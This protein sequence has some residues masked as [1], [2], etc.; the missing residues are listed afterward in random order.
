MQRTR[1]GTSPLLFDERLA[2]PAPAATRAHA[3]EV[4][5]RCD[6][7]PVVYARS[8]VRAVQVRGAWRSLVGLG[9][10][11]LAQLLFQQRHV[12]RVSLGYARLP[13]CG[14][15][16]RHLE[17]AWREATGDPPPAGPWWAR[18][19]RYTRQRAP[20]LL[21]E[22]FSPLVLSRRSRLAMGTGGGRA[23]RQQPLRR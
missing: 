17:R 5:L 16:R 4:V 21:M 12:E 9:T 10:R 1:Q 22:V 6:G 20:L 18:R 13:R 19:A 15:L 11:P 7:T 23:G 8:V 14:P 3:R 2:L